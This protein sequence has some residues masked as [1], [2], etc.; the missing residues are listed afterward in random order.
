MC[1]S[2]H[3][4]IEQTSSYGRSSTTGIWKNIF[5]R[6]FFYTIC[7]IHYFLT[8]LPPWRTSNV[9]FSCSVKIQP[10]YF[11]VR[12]VVFV[13]FFSVSHALIPTAGSVA[14]ASSYIQL[15]SW[16]WR[17]R[18]LHVSLG[19]LWGTLA[20]ISIVYFSSGLL[21][22]LYFKR[23]WHTVTYPLCFFFGSYMSVSTALSIFTQVY[24][25]TFAVSSFTSSIS[26][27]LVWPFP[28]SSL[29]IWFNFLTLYHLFLLLHFSLSD[30]INWLPI[31]AIM[32][33]LSTW[34]LEILCSIFFY[35]LLLKTFFVKV[36]IIVRY[37]QQKLLSVTL[38]RLVTFTTSSSCPCHSPFHWYPRYMLYHP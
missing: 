2:N 14:L 24:S 16:A 27:A 32:R 25:G 11:A 18:S 33:L 13:P 5:G 1:D 3:V 31:S 10:F 35:V 17:Q 9:A 38:T 12:S 23:E 15:Y 6:S 22:F 20:H 36:S 28:I 7:T 34:R 30:E 8:C 37:R 21:L 4:S 29:C 19:I 26:T